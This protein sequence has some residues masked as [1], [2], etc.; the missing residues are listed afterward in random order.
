VHP[1]SR[2]HDVRAEHVELCEITAAL[3]ASTTRLL[4]EIDARGR[5]RA[6]TVDATTEALDGWEH[7]AVA[8]NL[9]PAESI[10]IGP[11]APVRIGP[12]ADRLLDAAIFVI[13]R[14]ACTAVLVAALVY[15]C[16]VRRA[17]DVQTVSAFAAALSLPVLIMQAAE[18]F[19]ASFR[20][21]PTADRQ[22]LARARSKE[23]ELC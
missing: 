13:G 20:S 14:E 17:G 9:L 7:F 23:S 11:R 8:R 6:A 3:Y 19:S 4:C 22:P 5:V 10:L 18:R 12:K 15:L 21:R 16:G 2:A 1:G